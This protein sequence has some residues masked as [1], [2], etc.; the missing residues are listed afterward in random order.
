MIP[1][2]DR[3]P[4]T[5]G[6]VILTPVSGETNTFI[7][8]RADAPTTAGTP[9]NKALFDSIP[10]LIFTN[11]SVLTSA[12]VSDSTYSSLGF[13]Y[14]ATISL[15]GVTSTMVPRVVF[16]LQDVITN[17]FA[18]VAASYNGGIYIYARAVPSAT[19]TIPT[20]EITRGAE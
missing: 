7:M 14:R 20:I 3:V 12:F 10:S 15:A 9:I 6:K 2:V 8:T 13:G 17:N 1:V 18:P 19:T 16:G 4:N 5:P 11:T